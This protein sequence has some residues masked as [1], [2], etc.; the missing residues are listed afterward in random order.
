MIV[1]WLFLAVPWV[2][3]QFVIVVIPDHTQLLFLI[4]ATFLT[5]FF[6]FLVFYWQFSHAYLSYAQEKFYNLRGFLLL[7]H[8]LY[9]PSAGVFEHALF[10]F[11]CFNFKQLTQLKFQGQLWFNFKQGSVMHLSK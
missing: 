11:L 1:L 6:S 7:I 3:L 10:I 9:D 8:Y 4:F 5:L 2:S